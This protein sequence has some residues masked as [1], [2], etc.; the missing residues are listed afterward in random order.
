M[1]TLTAAAVPVLLAAAIP[2]H[3]DPSPGSGVIVAIAAHGTAPGRREAVALATSEIERRGLAARTVAASERLGVRVLR[4]DAGPGADPDAIAAGL[5]ASGAFLAAAPRFTLRLF[6]TLPN[7]PD[8]PLQWYV[9]SGDSAD[10]ELPGAWDVAQGDTSAVIAILD[11]G[12]DLGHPDLAARIW[13]NRGETPANGL[14]DDGNG[15]VDDVRGWD[16]GDGDANPN[17]GPVYDPIGLDVGFHGTFCAGIASGATD[18]GVGISGA[19]WNC[20]LMPLKVSDALGEIGSDAVAG[21]ILY[22]ADMRAAVISMSFGGPGNPGVPEFFQALIDVADSAGSLCVAAAGNDGV[23][24][25]SYPAAND[26]VLAVGATDETRAR[27]FF[28]NFGPWVDIAAPGSFMWS[29]ICR[30]YAI[31]DV[32]LLFYEILFGY[33]PPS[34]YMYGDG[35]SFACPLVA[36]VAG[37]VR[38]RQPYLSPQQVLAHLVAT[39]DPI[40]FD[41]PIGPKLNAWRAVHPGVLAAPA[42]ARAAGLAFAGATPNPFRAGTR[43]AFTLAAPSYARLGVHD[44]AGRSVRA[45]AEG[46]HAAGPHVVAWDGRDDRGRPVPGGVYFAALDAEGARVV[47]KVVRLAR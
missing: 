28:S 39:G 36:G 23:S 35:T 2:V 24:T 18:N 37:L 13:V 34:P 41:R 4:I 30:N 17:P 14:D 29:S 20:R 21:A 15:L 12:I 11:T 7:D 40:A 22:A 5:R 42:P 46:A 8:R 16:F 10:V 1:R 6:D 45:L 43:L 31:D 19:G 32:S 44:L 25:E 33:V 27:A 38:A 26:R 3:A 47:R 9:D